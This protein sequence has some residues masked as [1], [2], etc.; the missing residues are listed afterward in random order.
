MSFTGHLT[1]RSLFPGDNMMVS[2]TSLDCAVPLK[3][4][5]AYY[6]EKAKFCLNKSIRFLLEIHQVFFTTLPA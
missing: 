6:E 3:W 4:V 5:I 2:K 1:S